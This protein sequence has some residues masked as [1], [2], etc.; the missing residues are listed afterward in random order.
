MGV[1][2]ILKVFPE[3]WRGPELVIN[4]HQ[5]ALTEGLLTFIHVLISLSLDRN[6]RGSFYRK[7]WIN[8]ILKLA[9]HILGSDLTGGCMNPAAVSFY[10]DICLMKN[11]KLR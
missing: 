1:R 3:I 7:T 8:S 5:G 2:L 10:P 6:F 9:L 11:S 4:L